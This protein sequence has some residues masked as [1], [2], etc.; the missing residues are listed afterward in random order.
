MTWEL[1][2]ANAAVFWPKNNDPLFDL[3]GTFNPNLLGGFPSFDHRLVWTDVVAASPSSK[4]TVV[5]VDFL[6]QATFP[7]G[8]VKLR[9]LK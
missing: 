3:V 5:G 8:S 1:L 7:T 9:K 4:T 2:I 6:G